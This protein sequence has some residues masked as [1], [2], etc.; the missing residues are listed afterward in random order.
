MQSH[1]LGDP[2]LGDEDGAPPCL[3]GMRGDHRRNQRP[4]QRIGH[5][6]RI[7]L[8][9]VEFR[10]GRGQAAVLRRLAR[11]DVN[12]A[13]AFPVDVFCDV[14]QQREMAEGPDDRDRQVNVDAV[15]HPRHLDAIDLGVAHP[16]RLHPRTF[17]QVEHLVAVLFADRVTK[18]GAQQPDV[19]A[20]RLGRFAADLGPLDGPDRLQRDIGNLD[21]GF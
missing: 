17:D 6:G 18:D 15:K 14:G 21:H 13:A 9:L 3:G 12:A 5:R 11:G 8:C 1:Q 7:Q 10:V 2:V 16:E 4:L 19:G 20:H